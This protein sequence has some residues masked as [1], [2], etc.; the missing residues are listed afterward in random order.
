MNAEGIARALGG[1]RSGRQW[2]GRCPAHDDRNPSLLIFDALTTVQ[3]RCFAGCAPRDVIAALRKRRILQH[4]VPESRAT[5]YGTAPK[6]SGRTDE[7]VED[8]QRFGLDIWNRS[9]DPRSTI[10]EMYLNRRGL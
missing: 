4:D 9:I 1:K 8:R 6:C 10:G 3:F 7:G 5:L 2:L